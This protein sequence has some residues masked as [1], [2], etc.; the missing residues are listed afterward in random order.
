MEPHTAPHDAVVSVVRE[1]VLASPER[2][3]S[4]DAVANALKSR[5]FRRPPGSPRLLTRLRRIR[6]LLVSPS[7]AITLAEVGEPDSRVES[8]APEGE[9]IARFEGTADDS[10]PPGREEP[11]E[12]GS[13]A[14]RGA[15][16]PGESPSGAPGAAAGRGRRRRRRRRRGGHR[17]AAAPSP[18]I[19]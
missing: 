18:D 12:A 10:G 2:S 6:E 15:A 4:M 16:E 17:P 1:L 3:V 5:G 7:G 11:A 8:R 9:P 14:E 19:A 13:A